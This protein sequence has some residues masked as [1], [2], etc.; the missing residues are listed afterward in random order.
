VSVIMRGVNY[1]LMI[2]ALRWDW[3]AAYASF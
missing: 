2:R 3:N 1:L